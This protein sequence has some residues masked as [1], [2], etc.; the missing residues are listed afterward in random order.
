MAKRNLCYH[1]TRL[2]KK[3]ASGRE[4][5]LSLCGIYC[6]HECMDNS[7]DRVARL[8]ITIEFVCLTFP[9][10][11]ADMDGQDMMA[12]ARQKEKFSYKVPFVNKLIC[13]L[14]TL[15]LPVCL[16]AWLPPRACPPTCMHVSI[17]LPP[18]DD[19]PLFVTFR[20]WREMGPPYE[21]HANVHFCLF[22]FP[23]FSPKPGRMNEWRKNHCREDHW[24]NIR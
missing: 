23:S 4:R 21:M 7:C 20:Q 11:G 3:L 17:P 14:A 12:K 16:S 18:P 22:L 13:R 15:L 5:A 19:P 24:N 10:R 6:W 2:R 9:S 8:T 1:L